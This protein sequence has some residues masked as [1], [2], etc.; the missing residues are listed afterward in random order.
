MDIH[1]AD[2]ESIGD[3]GCDFTPCPQA[4]IEPVP[5]LQRDASGGALLEAG[6]EAGLEKELAVIQ[7]GC[8]TLALQGHQIYRPFSQATRW[9]CCLVRLG[10]PQLGAW[11]SIRKWLL[12][13][14]PNADC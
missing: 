1:R 14:S 6:L 12:T 10:I 11:C 8:E 3:L 2:L 5:F 7:G 9:Q 13:R 4:D